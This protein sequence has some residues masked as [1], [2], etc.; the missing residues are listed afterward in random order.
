MCCQVHL[1]S[2]FS[3]TLLSLFAPQEPSGSATEPAGAYRSRYSLHEINCTCDS[4]RAYSR[5]T[6]FSHSGPS[7]HQ[8]PNNSASKGAVKIGTPG[9]LL[10]Y[11][12][13]ASAVM[14]AKCEAC[15]RVRFCATSQE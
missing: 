11:T 7:N 13:S 4:G 8:C 6:F 12:L 10:P 1:V 2:S 9:T 3:Q 5:T 15:S 14:P